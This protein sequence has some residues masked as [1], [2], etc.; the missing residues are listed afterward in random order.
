MAQ[1]SLSDLLTAA[2]ARRASLIDPRHETAYRL[3]NGFAEGWPDLTIDVYGDTALLE[4][5]ADSAGGGSAH[6]NEPVH[7]SDKARR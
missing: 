7:R 1:S 6:P 2:I 5:H 3:F 4:D